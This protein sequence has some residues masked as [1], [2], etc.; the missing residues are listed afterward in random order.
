MPGTSPTAAAQRTLHRWG[1]LLWILGIGGGL[2]AMTALP[3]YGD[4]GF[5]Y[6]S[7]APCPGCGMTR[8]CSALLHGDLAASWRW[9]PAGI[10]LALAVAAVLG[11]AVHEG[12][13]GRPTFRRPAERWATTAA[14]VFV[15]VLGALWILRVVVHPA[16]SPDPLRPG[17]LAARLLE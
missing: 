14:V 11:L 5:R 7:G 9:H 16:W 10:P 8:S 1:P 15:A 4:C 17:S 13:T 12:L 2:A 3:A 6:L